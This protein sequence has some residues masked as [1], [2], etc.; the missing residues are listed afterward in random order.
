MGVARSVTRLT[1]ETANDSEAR[2][3]APRRALGFV[4]RLPI[5]LAHTPR[6]ILSSY[7]GMSLVDFS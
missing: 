6:V 4:A 5:A 2:V 1:D 3:D 7:L